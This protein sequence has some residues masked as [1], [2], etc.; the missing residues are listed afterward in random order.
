MTTLG[1]RNEL[2]VI[3]LTCVVVVCD[4]K[5]FGV[6]SSV[7]LNMHL[8]PVIIALIKVAYMKV[9]CCYITVVCLEANVNQMVRW[10]LR[11]Y[12]LMISQL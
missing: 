2:I 6:C 4:S 3:F 8:Q 9:P 5:F 7:F 10:Y 12:R 11:K 1:R